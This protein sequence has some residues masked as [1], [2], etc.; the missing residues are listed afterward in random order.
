MAPALQPDQTLGI[1]ISVPFCRAKC[2]F[3]NFASGVSSAA[4]IDTYITQLCAEI[5]SAH[6]TA[7]N[8]HAHLPPTVD[9]LYFGGGTPSLL[10]PAQLDRI[11]TALH[12][13]FHIAPPPPRS[14]SKP[15][16]ARSPTP[17]SPPPNPSAS[18]A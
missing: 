6:S 9:T 14:P 3:C 17:S 2:S 13:N 5:D 11:F 1:Y 7:S 16:P 8:L 12:R 15:P 4:A 10:T 18:T